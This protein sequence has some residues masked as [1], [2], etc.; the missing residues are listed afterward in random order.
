[1]IYV[2]FLVSIIL[3]QAV[4]LIYLTKITDKMS[5]FT[6][7]LKAK[8]NFQAAKL[9][10]LGTKIDELKSGAISTDEAAEITGL[11]DAN[12][13]KIDELIAK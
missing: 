3:I 10:E 9:D 8:L 7:D 13:A 11:V 2:N 1:M 5:A 4:T 6:E 12:G